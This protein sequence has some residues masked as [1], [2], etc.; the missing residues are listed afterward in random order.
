[1]V[2]SKKNYKFDLGVQGLSAESNIKVIRIKEM[3][4][5]KMSSWLLNKFSLSVP[6][7]IYREYCGEYAHWSEII[8]PLTPRIWL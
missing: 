8:N 2:D 1:M 6:E 3:I 7:E 4:A 5:Y